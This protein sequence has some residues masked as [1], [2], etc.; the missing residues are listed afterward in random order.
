MML[1][2]IES[3]V[4]RFFQEHPQAVETGRG[5]AAWLGM[6]EGATVE[7]ALQGLA[8]RNWLNFHETSCVKAYSLTRDERLLERIQES[9]KSV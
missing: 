7:Q 2:E 8:S 1:T 6:N 4:L 9:L 5:I 3:R